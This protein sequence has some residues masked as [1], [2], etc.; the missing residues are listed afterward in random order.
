M[1]A[2]ATRLNADGYPAPHGR[3]GGWRYDSVGPILSNPAYTGDF[4]GLRWTNAK[5]YRAE[6]GKV[7]KVTG[8]K[9]YVSTPREHWVVKR[10]H[11][12]GIIDRELFDRA[13][14]LLDS[15]RASR[16][17]PRHAPED[18]P[19]VLSCL[20]RCGRCGAIMQGLTSGR[21][22]Y[23]HCGNREYNGNSACDGTVVRED[24][25]LRSVAE[26]LRTEFFD[27]DG[28]ELEHEAEGATRIEIARKG[29]LTP[30]TLPKAF[31]RVK[32]LVAP[33]RQASVDRKRLEKRH[34]ALAADV[35]K[36]RRNLA[37][38]DPENIP[39]V[40]EVIRGLEAERSELEAEL[41]KRPPSEQDV[42]AEAL[43]VLTALYWLRLF[44]L[45]AAEAGNPHGAPAPEL[46]RY[47]SRLSGIRIDTT[48]RPHQL[49]PRHVFT[50]GEISFRGQG[51]VT[52]VLTA[53]V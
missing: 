32:G 34:K 16:S 48:L 13:Q 42:N 52:A 12:E 6:N 26:Y 24:K 4:V 38:V 19:Y 21:R 37:L 9:R 36:A 30:S 17:R 2:I 11:H 53:K 1:N 44:F 33:P 41:R 5:Y 40:Q 20:L 15:N 46:R 3:P 8:G 28:V 23:Y 35:D 14:A 31:A 43:E 18:N 10:D 7:V 39:T 49:G 22:R 47:L 27:L 45:G 50:G 51:N 29:E 25:V